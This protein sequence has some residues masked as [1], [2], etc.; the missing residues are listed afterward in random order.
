MVQ[1]KIYMALIILFL[2]PFAYAAKPECTDSDGND[3]FTKGVVTFLGTYEDYCYDETRL[4][5]RICDK[6]EM[7][8]EW[9]ECEEGCMEGACETYCGNE[10]CNGGESCGTCP[11]DCGACCGNDVIDANEDCDSC[12]EDVKCGP[13]EKCTDGICVSAAYCGDGVCEED[14]N[15]ANCPADCACEEGY[16]CLE[17]SC[18]KKERDYTVFYII[19]IIF[20]VILV[21]RIYKMFKKRK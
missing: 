17:G 7:A 21:H 5:E 10:I 12:P 16:K 8:F 15:C 11:E 9:Y 6:G 20:I 13:N 1:L 19:G 2:L 4:K 18:V 14:E 3:P